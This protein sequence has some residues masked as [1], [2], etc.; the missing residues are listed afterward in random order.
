MNCFEARRE[1]AAFWRRTMP[2][3]ERARLL[4]HLTECAQCDRSF[5]VFALSAPVVHSQC[6]PDAIVTAAR[7]SLDL[8]RPRRF[9]TARAES[10]GQRA[11]QR[12]GQV[13]AAAVLLMIGGITAWSSTRWPLQ[14]FAETVVADSPEFDAAAYSSDSE[15]TAIDAAAQEPALFDSIAPESSATGGNDL[16]G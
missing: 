15:A 2:L 11:P 12:L 16:A 6:Q 13:A 3:A 5:R 4:E 14:N 1:F 9:A 10:F 8:V 7:P